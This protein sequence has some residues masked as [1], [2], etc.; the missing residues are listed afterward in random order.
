MG[1]EKTANKVIWPKLIYYKRTSGDIRKQ[2]GMRNIAKIKKGLKAR[3][4]ELALAKNLDQIYQYNDSKTVEAFLKG[5]FWEQMI[6]FNRID[7]PP[8]EDI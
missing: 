6:A 8:K 1:V 5:G 2:S 3:E 7:A 4:V